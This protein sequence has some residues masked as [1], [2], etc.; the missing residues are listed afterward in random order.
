MVL[1]FKK[2][3]FFLTLS[4][5]M[6]CSAGTSF[7][8]NLPVPEFKAQYTI[9]HNGV[10]IGHIELRVE[11]IAE[12]QYQLISSTETS[13]ILAFI[14]DN[15]ASET[16]TFDVVNNQLRASVYKYRERLID[17]QKDVDVVFDWDALKAINTAKGHTWKLDITAGVLDKALMQVALMHDLESGKQDMT[18]HVAD[19]GSLKKYEFTYED[20]EEIKIDDRTYNTV[21][22]ARLKNDKPPITYYWCATDLHYLPVLVKRK[23][24]YGTFEMVLEKVSFKP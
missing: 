14:R 6:L 8:E 16:S 10:E 5:V 15:E 19:G 12:Q 7:A 20:S 22:L 11:K 3:A 9:K 23:K 13:G 17:G 21:R 4:F 24:T 18:Y 2:A 1:S